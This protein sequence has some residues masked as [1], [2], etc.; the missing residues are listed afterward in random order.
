MDMKIL[1]INPGTDE[2]IDGKITREIPYIFAKTL[3]APHA[4]AAIAALTP[5]VYQVEIHD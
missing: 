5:A 3:F 4:V 2:D 1:L